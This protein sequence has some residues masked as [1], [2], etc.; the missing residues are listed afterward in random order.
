MATARKATK[1]TARKASKA[2]KEVTAAPI[3]PKEECLDFSKME[4]NQ[5][6]QLRRWAAACEAKKNG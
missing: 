2:P 6:R 3:T 1:R 4:S 5:K